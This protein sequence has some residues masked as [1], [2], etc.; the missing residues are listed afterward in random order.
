MIRDLIILYKYIFDSLC[1]IYFKVDNPYCLNMLDASILLLF[2]HCPMIIQGCR[3][4]YAIG[5]FLKG[6]K[7]EVPML[8]MQLNIIFFEDYI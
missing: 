6:G 7:C 1:L 2:C 4:I 8:F 5:G 3:D